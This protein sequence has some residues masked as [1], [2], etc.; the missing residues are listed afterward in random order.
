MPSINGRVTEATFATI[1]DR[2]KGRLEGWKAKQLSLV[3]TQ[4]LV[5]SV[6]TTIPF[7]TM[8]TAILPIGVCDSIDMI[9]RQFI[10]GGNKETRSVNIVRW[11]LVTQPKDRGGLGIWSAREMNLACMAKLGWRI[12]NEGDELWVKVFT[13]KYAREGND[14]NNWKN[15]AGESNTWK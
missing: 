4:V 7:Y 3:G 12:M 11:D 8:Q 14:T 1:L 13:D 2:M 5:Q 10:W 6:L 9:T 15:K